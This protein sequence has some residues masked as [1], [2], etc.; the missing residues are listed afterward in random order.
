MEVEIKKILPNPEQPRKDFDK[1]ELQ[2]LADSIREHGIIQPLVVEETGKG[3]Y[4]LTDGERRLRAA[5]LA[6][7][8]TVPVVVN[9]LRT[10]ANSGSERLIKALVA[11]IQRSDLSVIE[12][13]RAFKRMMDEGGMSALE[14]SKKLGIS[15]VRVSRGL[16]VLN[17]EPII[18]HWIEVGQLQADLH[19]V[20]ALLSLPAGDVRVKTA[21]SLSKNKFNIKRSLEAIDKINQASAQYSAGK[22]PEEKKRNQSNI[23][24][25][26][27]AS[28]KTGDVNRPRWDALA[29]VGKVP[30]WML[31]EI[32]VRDVCQMCSWAENANEVV[33]KDCPLVSLLVEMIGKV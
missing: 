18:Q 3:D 16:R 31:M 8:T 13:G 33:C 7:L 24:S 17:L 22:E 30:P 4:I 6:G 23:P 5:R 26:R 12:E 27:F 11:N 21:Q 14:V 29:S 28:K 2:S 9:P 1:L 15:Y 19:L 25:L 32:S 20:D 10:G